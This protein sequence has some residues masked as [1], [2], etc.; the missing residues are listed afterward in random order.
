MQPALL[1]CCAVLDLA[2]MISLKPALLHACDGL[3]LRSVRSPNAGSGNRMRAPPLASPV[4]NAFAAKILA[5]IKSCLTAERAEGGRTGDRSEQC[6]GYPKHS[7]HRSVPSNE[8]PG[9]DCD[10]GGSRD[11][12]HPHA[13]AAGGPWP[14]DADAPDGHAAAP[15]QVRPTVIVGHL[16]DMG[17]LLEICTPCALCKIAHPAGNTIVPI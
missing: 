14:A 17:S 13:S 15:R 10:A 1:H 16:L 4:T 9:K 5:D 8:N 2:G 6:A 7:R 12:R 11:G 3:H